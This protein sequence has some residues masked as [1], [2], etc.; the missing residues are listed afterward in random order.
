MGKSTERTT[1]ASAP[2]SRHASP[3]FKSGEGRGAFFQ[4]KLAINTPGDHLEQEADRTADRVMAAPV[5]H[6][7][8]RTSFFNVAAGVQRQ[9]KDQ[10]S[11]V[12]TEGLSITYEQMKDQ[13]GFEE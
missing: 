1:K 11:D 8:E 3:F 2:Q 9:P 6:A 12:L 10:T 5:G 13:P 4:P 7:L